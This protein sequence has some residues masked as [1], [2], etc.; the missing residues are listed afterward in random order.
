MDWSILPGF[1]Y[2]FL[3]TT[4]VSTN[5]VG[6]RLCTTADNHSAK[7]LAQAPRVF[8]RSCLITVISGIYK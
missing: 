3:D 2:S 7:A 5:R 6:F 8:L 4:F 1:N